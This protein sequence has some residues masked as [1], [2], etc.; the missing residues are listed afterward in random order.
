MR[1]DL[2]MN[3]FER[4]SSQAETFICTVSIGVLCPSI[5][6]EALIRNNS[7]TFHQLSIVAQPSMGVI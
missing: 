5:N 4:L 2:N 6:I 1:I 7:T 3:A